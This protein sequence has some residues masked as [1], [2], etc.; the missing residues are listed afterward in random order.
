MVR[1]GR[2]LAGATANADALDGERGWM[3]LR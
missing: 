2:P 3:H 1:H